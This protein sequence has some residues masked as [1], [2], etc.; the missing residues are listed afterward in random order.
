M[1]FN[2]VSNGRVFLC[3]NFGGVMEAAVKDRQVSGFERHLQTGLS[4]VLVMLV[5]WGANKI[6]DSLETMVRFDERLKAI[7]AQLA[8][9][10]SADTLVRMRE[11]E[12]RVQALERQSGGG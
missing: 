3:L 8:K 12:I 9:I 4:M 10:E 7:E 5:G 11:L 1:G 2:P 6:S